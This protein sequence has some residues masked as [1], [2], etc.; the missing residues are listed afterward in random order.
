MLRVSN[1]K[2][3]YKED[4]D[5][6]IKNKLKKIFKR[7]INEYKINKKSIDARDKSNILFVYTIFR[8]QFLNPLF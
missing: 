3:N 5:L 4:Q 6:S 7:D 8:F 1:I 2:V